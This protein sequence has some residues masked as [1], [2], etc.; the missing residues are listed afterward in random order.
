MIAIGCKVIIFKEKLQSKIENFDRLNLMKNLTDWLIEFNEKFDRL[1][2]SN[3]TVLQ[4]NCN[5][6]ATAFLYYLWAEMEYYKILKIQND[7]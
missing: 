5:N 4:T 3:K 2:I 7:V 6:E 1:V